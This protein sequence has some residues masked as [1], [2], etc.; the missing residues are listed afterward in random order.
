[1]KKI[2]L[3]A[4][5][6]LL[7]LSAFA[8]QPDA[9]TKGY[10]YNPAAGK[11]IDTN[12]Q[13]SATEGEL[14]TVKYKN[15]AEKA[16]NPAADYPDRGFDG[17]FY[18]R[19]SSS[20]G[21]LSLQ[22]QPLYNGGGYAQFIVKETEK[23]W[24]ITHPYPNTNGNVPG[25]VNDNLDA[26]QGAYLQVVEGE[27]VFAKDTENEG[28]YWQFV[29]E[30]TYKKIAGPTYPID[31]TG[32]AAKVAVTGNADAATFT[33]TGTL[34]NMFQIKPFDVSEF[35]GYG[36]KKIVVEFS[37]ANAGQFHGHAYGNGNDPHWDVLTGMDNAPEWL[38]M[39]D[40]KFEVAL[41]ADV[42]EDFTVFTWFDGSAGPITITAYF[43][44][45]DLGAETP[46]PTPE[47]TIAFPETG[48]KGYIYNP[49]IGVF[50]DAN[51]ALATEG[52]I[53]AVYR[54]D[55]DSSSDIRFGVP[56]AEA[57]KHLRINGENPVLQTTDPYYSKWGYE[58][59]EGGK[60]LLKAGYDYAD[61]C[62]KGYYL[63]ATE[64]AAFEFVAE[65]VD[66]SYW[67]FITE[68]EIATRIS[69]V[70]K[71]PATQAIFNVAGQQIKALQKGLNIVNGK[72]VYVK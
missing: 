30:D 52:A 31:L 71:Q 26:Y 45:E 29:D 42:I 10:F 53:F 64:D 23:G 12:A 58:A 1:M 70:E 17:G 35:R 9:G 56:G 16:A 11:F 44:K 13:L 33:P 57:N 69:S 37:G 51:G 25:W 34:Q 67:Q 63:T 18:I 55:T 8:A 24:L 46:E 47:P 21:D 19:F 20:K 6:A 7:G 43:S 68:E 39:G 36:Y 22:S 60:F 72:K 41:T 48:A 65:P 38:A 54:K 50:I 5:V 15:D 66:G 14:F 61:Y 2:L 4:I 40:S 28:A 62:T 3:T 49:A 32:D 27:L 59:A